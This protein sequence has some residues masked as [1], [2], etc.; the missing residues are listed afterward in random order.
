MTQKKG[1]FRACNRL[2]RPEEFQ[3]VF[4]SKFRSGDRSL[5]LIAREN[6]KLESRLGLAVPKKH[7]HHSVKRNK[8]KRVIRESFRLNQEQ[9]Q[10]LDVVVVIKQNIDNSVDELDMT[11]KKHW[12]KISQ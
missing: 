7:I 5:L 1:R 12:N 6:G 4:S 11:L 10:G 9:L 8:I 3:R 2:K